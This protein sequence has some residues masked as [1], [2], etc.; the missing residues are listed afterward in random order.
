MA[1]RGFVFLT[2]LAVALTVARHGADLR[3]QAASPRVVKIVGETHK[4]ML[5]D[6]GTVAGWGQWQQAELGSVAGLG[7]NRTVDHL[8]AIALPGKAID[9]AAG[10]QTSFALLADGTVV[11][12]GRGDRGQLGVEPS[13]RPLL[14][15]ST[16]AFEY[17]GLE[18]PTAIPSLAGVA[19]IA[20]DGGAAYALMRDGSV[21]A[22]GNG[23]LRPGAVPGLADVVALSAASGAVLAVTKDGRVFSWGSN[24][25]GALGRAPRVEGAL[26]TPADVPG[27]SDVAQAVTGS[28][29]SMALK[30][31]GTVWVW[32]SNWQQQFGFP[33]PSD[34]ATLNGGWVLTPQQVPG[35][36][37]AVEIALGISG[38]HTLV[39]VKDGTLRV[40]GNNDW[41]QLG[42]GAGAGFQ[43]RPVT[44]KIAGVAR[45]FAA[46]NNSF[47]LRTD[48]SLWAWGAGRQ[49]WPLNAYVRVPT[50]APPDLK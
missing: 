44:P 3:A 1:N 7:A 39:R 15:T 49:E 45:V 16:Q 24:F 12:W 11:G 27:L 10:V 29:V 34:Q 14:P 18:R 20:A 21:R 35:V 5:R 13:A 36:T 40:W 46:G 42:T 9:I 26:A 28:G 25:Y 17:R 30:K 50:P 22:W 2:A 6:D 48:G 19:A 31:D 47:A 41:G 33:A 32:G 37:N 4:L 43:V 38:R 8:V 23:V